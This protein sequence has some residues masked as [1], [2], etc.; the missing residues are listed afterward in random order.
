MSLT[1]DAADVGLD[2]TRPAT[3]TQTDAAAGRRP[4]AGAPAPPPVG[5]SHTADIAE[6]PAVDITYETMVEGADAELLWQHYWA[7]FEPLADV[8]VQRQVSDYEEMIELFANPRVL[9]IVAREAGRPV[10]FVM[11]TNSLEDVPE[12]SPRFLRRRYP[13]HAARDSIYVGIYVAVEPSHRGITLS[14][15]L[16]LECWQ[17]VANQ[18]GVLVIDVCEFN[19]RTFDTDVLLRQ[20][21]RAF[22]NSNVA[23]LDRQTWY[24]M[25]LPEP[26]I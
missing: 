20:I 16:Y 11:I 26:M 18:S 22:P 12:L 13:E 6:S 24:G 3:R 4:T 5:R 7:N 8:S 14:Y 10:G 2:T 23:E 21:A 15:R 19:R 1:R 25:E 9:K 17:L